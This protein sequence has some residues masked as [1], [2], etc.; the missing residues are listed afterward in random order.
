MKDD[1]HISIIS[2]SGEVG[3]EHSTD[4]QV[5][6]KVVP[7]YSAYFD[8]VVIPNKVVGNVDIERE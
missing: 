1:G 2:V 5:T 4:K 3:G 6:F 8:V 7:N